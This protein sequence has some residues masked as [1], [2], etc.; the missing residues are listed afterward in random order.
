M[1][2]RIRHFVGVESSEQLAFIDELHALGLSSTIE[3]PE[4]VVV[5]DQSTGKSSVLQA[6]TEIS[7]PVQERTCTRF[8]IQIS[9]RQTASGHNGGVKATISPG[10]ITER[11]DAFRDRIQGFRVDREA[12]TTEVMK[13][14]IEKATE[15]MFGKDD[16]QGDSLCDAVLRIE[17]SGPDEMH[18]SIVDL[19]GLVQNTQSRKRHPGMA[20]GTHPTPNGPMS[21]TTKG[22]IAET[23]VRKYLDNPRNIVLLILGDT[24]VELS[25]SLEI[26]ATVPG[27]ESRAIGVLNKCDKREEGAG[28]WMDSLLQNN[29]STAPRLDHGWFGL[30]NRKPHESHL[31]DQERDEAEENEF[32]KPVWQSVPKE[33]FGIKALMDY[34]DRERRAQLQ[35]GMPNIISEIRQKL[36]DCETT[37]KNMGEARTTP[38]AQRS[39]VN[40]FCHSMERMAEA[41]LR[42]KYQDIPSTDPKI[43]LCYLVQQRV[44]EFTKAVVPTQGIELTFDNYE[45]ELLDLWNSPPG[46]W[47]DRISRS[48]GI[49]SAIYEEAMISRGKSLAGTVHPDVEEK[50]FRMLSAHW[51][52]FATQLVEDAKV[53]VK[54]CYDVLLR[55]AIPNNR[56]RLEVSRLITSQLE[57]W[58]KDADGTL[59]ELIEDNRVRPLF[60]KHPYFESHLAVTEKRRS[61]IFSAPRGAATG[62][63]AHA[64]DG[65]P[66]LSTLLNNIMQTRTKLETYY[67]IAVYR[68]IDN[69]TTQ[70]IERH[71]LGPKCPL[72]AVCV[73]TFTNIDD[74]Q[75]DKIAG[76]DKVDASTRKRLEETKERYRK[77]LERWEQLSVL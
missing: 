76:E 49:Y 39:F 41:S 33:R 24:D 25:K 8:P 52:K 11:D 27:V 43:R 53:C 3:L 45:A 29:L 20:N 75:L 7:F 72:R 12:L 55:L 13:E 46:T 26:V 58:N 22:A 38:A 64:A 44:D 1:G 16:V 69:V 4:L 70:V 62:V 31:T 10:P 35:K 21:M 15:R 66:H 2:N 28:M 32:V 60:T 6:I 34:I 40:R 77:A 23:I 47:E 14:M 42:A 63:D 71:V 59:Q 56:V 50:V 19:P 36:R 30:R 9:F 68:F 17:R 73:E 37:L 61:E 57:V 51:N 74:E 67:R 54:E 5:G 65:P 48:P 18:W